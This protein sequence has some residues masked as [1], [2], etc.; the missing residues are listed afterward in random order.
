MTLLQQTKQIL[1]K[2]NF[3]EK[4]FKNLKELLLIIYCFC[5]DFI[6]EI[7]ENIIK[8]LPLQKIDKT[9]P[10]IKT[11]NLSVSEIT[12]LQFAVPPRI[13]APYEGM[14]VTLKS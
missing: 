5:D 6:T 4:I 14:N 1:K 13:S 2:E 10:P 9:H 7:K 11:G 3:S 8:K 12:T